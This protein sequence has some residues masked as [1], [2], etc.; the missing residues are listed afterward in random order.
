MK[1]ALLDRY[2]GVDFQ[3]YLMDVSYIGTYP[4]CQY[5]YFGVACGT[6]CNCRGPC[7]YISGE[8]SGGECLDGW[9]GSNCQTRKLGLQK[10]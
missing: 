1:D 8:C 3:M 10:T 9:T 6:V 5:G 4:D 7:D 2:T